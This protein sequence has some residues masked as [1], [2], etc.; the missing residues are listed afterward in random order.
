MTRSAKA[1]RAPS[2]AAPARSAPPRRDGDLLERLFPLAV[3]TGAGAFLL[4]LL[5]VAGVTYGALW[6]TR[7]RRKA[8]RGAV[9]V[10]CA[11]P[12]VGALL[13]GLRGRR[14]GRAGRA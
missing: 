6:A 12:A 11:A 13:M 10:L 8:V 3:A 5:P 9:A 1:G 7:R 14:W 2:A 4:P